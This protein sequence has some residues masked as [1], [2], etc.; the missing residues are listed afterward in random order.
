MFVM[1]GSEHLPG[2]D[3][4]RGVEAGGAVALIVM[5]RALGGPG[6]HRQGRLG[7]IQRLDLRFLIHRENHGPFGRVEIQAADVVDLLDELRVLG[8]LEPLLAVGLQPE[9]MPDPQHRVL[10]HPSLASHRPRRPVRRVLGRTLQRPGDH[11]LH[12]IVG[13]RAGSSR[14]GLIQQSLK[15]ALGEPVAPLRDRR[16]RH[17][18]QLGDLTVG[19][20]PGRGQ[21]DPCAHR[22]RLASLAARRPGL[23]RRA[24]LVGQDDLYSGRSRHI[25][26]LP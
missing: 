20:L 7:P 17:A 16:R 14:P 21:H 22:Q 1:Q 19:Q 12:L 4:Q 15:P 18:L 23:Q 26:L 10:G 3:V 5:G 25:P 6:E 9:G 2:L 8:Q 11:R 13:D 24:F